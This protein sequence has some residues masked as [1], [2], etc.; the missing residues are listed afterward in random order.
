VQRSSIAAEGFSK[1][2]KILALLIKQAD[3]LLI[4]LAI[5]IL[6]D[7]QMGTYLR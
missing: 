4:A 2:A 6:I 3:L 1:A 5:A 7:D